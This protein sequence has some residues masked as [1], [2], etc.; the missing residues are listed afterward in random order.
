MANVVERDAM[1]SFQS[2][3]RGDEIMKICGLIEG[4]RVGEIKNAIEEAILDGEIKNDHSSAL[5]YLNKIKEN[6]LN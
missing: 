5:E 2:P 6:F 4:R 3:I 1:K